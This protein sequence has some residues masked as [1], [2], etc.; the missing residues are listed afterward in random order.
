MAWLPLVAIRMSQ[1]EVNVGDVG[2]PKGQ[3]RRSGSACFVK[4]DRRTFQLLIRVDQD[5]SGQLLFGLFFFLKK[6]DSWFPSP[7][8]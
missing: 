4:D 1:T 3:T 8:R 5:K 7:E 2:L 6:V